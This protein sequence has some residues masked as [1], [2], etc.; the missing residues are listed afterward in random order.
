LTVHDTQGYACRVESPLWIPVI[1]LKV[2]KPLLP[3]FLASLLQPAQ[4]AMAAAQDLNIPRSHT[5]KEH[6]LDNFEDQGDLAW[7]TERNK[8]LGIHLE[9][10]TE[11][12]PGSQVLRLHY[13][14]GEKSSSPI[15]PVATD[16][17]PSA[18]TASLAFSPVDAT[19]YDH[20]FLRIRGDATQGFTPELELR[21]MAGGNNAEAQSGQAGEFIISPVTSEWQW[22]EIPL[23][24]ISG[25]TDW[26][27]LHQIELRVSRPHNWLNSGSYYLDDIA[28]VKTGEPGPEG[29]DLIVAPRKQR[30]ENALGG[31][32]SARTELKK[33]LNGWPTQVLADPSRMPTEDT[34]FVKRLALDTWRGLDGLTDRVRGLPLDR[35]QFHPESVDV[36]QAQLG[37]YTSVTNIGFYLASVVAA[38]KLG[39]ID[40]AT[41][42]RK[43]TSTLDSLAQMETFQ[44]FFY[45]YYVISTLERTTNLISYVDSAWLTSGLIVVRQAF[46]ELAER[47]SRLIRQADYRFFYDEERQWMAHGYYV[48]QRMRS[49][50]HYG[51]LYAESR[52]GSLIAIGKGD[53]PAQHWFSLMRTYPEMYYDWHLKTPVNRRSKTGGGFTWEGGYYE[54][55]GK[56]FVPSWGG[57]MFEALMPVVMLDEVRLA[58]KNLGA[59]DLLHV[60]IQKDYTLKTLGYPVWGMSP[61]ST[62]GG[63]YGEFGV[64]PLGTRSYKPGVVTSHAAGLAIMIDPASAISNLKELAKRYP[65]YGDFGFYDAVNPATGAVAYDYLCLDQSMLFLALTNHLTDHAIQR[66]FAADPIIAKALPLLKIENFFD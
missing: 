22:V 34:L 16:Q 1:V 28:L 3:C 8:Q 64:E 59:N 42:V 62:P 7:H 13:Q 10:V 21:L 53:V 38:N 48:N 5:L 66:L 19:D 31:E 25:I 54:W 40:H 35:V 57:S 20:L 4:L 50:Y 58:P 45:N 55:E 37:D 52:L 23:N 56:R 2:C 15:A 36:T 44:G 51:A 32:P 12:K 43:I 60:G 18:Y 47:C 6:L 27:N 24:H 41:A 65:I 61:S 14:F 29:T 9:R 63:G 49:I 26:K 11:K 17:S 30:W 46:P 33:R 39:F